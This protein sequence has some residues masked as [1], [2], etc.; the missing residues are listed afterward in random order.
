MMAHFI[1]FSLHLQMLL[2]LMLSTGDPYI[3]DSTTK[4]SSNIV[5]P[6]GN[7]RPDT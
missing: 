5:N 4:A 7:L 6:M 3:Q 2:K 1:T